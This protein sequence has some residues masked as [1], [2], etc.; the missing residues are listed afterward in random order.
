MVS[1][2]GLSPVEVSYKEQPAL[3]NLQTAREEAEGQRHGKVKAYIRA[4][5]RVRLQLPPNNSTNTSRFTE[6]I[7]QVVAVRTRA[8]NAP[9][10]V[11]VEDLAGAQLSNRYYQFQVAVVGNGRPDSTA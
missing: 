8:H 10:L 1:L 9:F 6:E 4:G 5:M 2:G 11:E 3:Y 7:F